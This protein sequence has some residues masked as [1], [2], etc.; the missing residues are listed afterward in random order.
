MP[1]PC[2]WLC[3]RHSTDAA[4]KGPQVDMALVVH[5]Q[6][7]ALLERLSADVTALFWRRVDAH[8]LDFKPLGGLIVHSEPLIG[9]AWHS[10]EAIVI[11][12]VCHSWRSYRNGRSRIIVF[13]WSD[14]HEL[15]VVLFIKFVA[16][17]L[18]RGALGEIIGVVLVCLERAWLLGELSLSLNAH[19]GPFEA[20]LSLCLHKREPVGWAELRQTDVS[21]VLDLG[22][23][24]WRFV[25]FQSDGQSL[26]LLLLPLQLCILKEEGRLGL[27]EEFLQ[28]LTLS[29][30][31]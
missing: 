9:V 2:A 13:F 12:P 8:K 19:F 10:L 16:H 11:F 26:T 28:E 14:S 5:D 30:T 18:G 6:A 20:L 15:W 31:L 3:E 24:G 4:S 7:R 25:R 29:L 21:V 17:I 1:I 27:E 23:L 22:W